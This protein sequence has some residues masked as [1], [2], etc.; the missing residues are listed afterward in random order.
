VRNNWLVA[1]A[2]SSDESGKI[3]QDLQTNL[4]TF[5]RMKLRGE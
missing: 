4:L 3:F 1:G 2:Q 5:L